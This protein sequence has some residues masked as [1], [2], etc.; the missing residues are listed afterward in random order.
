MLNDWNYNSE[1]I[2]WIKKNY[3]NPL[4]TKQFGSLKLTIYA[5][6]QEFRK[7]TIESLY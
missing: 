4:A 2:D 6:S 5:P 3:D 1:M 7:L